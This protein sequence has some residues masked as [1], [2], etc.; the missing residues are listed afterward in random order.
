MLTR[1]Q[2]LQKVEDAGRTDCLMTDTHSMKSVSEGAKIRTKIHMW[3]L[4]GDAYSD[5]DGTYMGERWVAK[6]IPWSQR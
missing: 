5:P 6:K 4:I 3:T 2:T 1:R